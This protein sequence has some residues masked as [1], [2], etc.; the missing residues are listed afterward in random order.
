LYSVEHD[1]EAHWNSIGRGK[2]QA[3][4][5]IRKISNGTIKLWRFGAEYDLRGFQHT[6]AKDSTF[7][8]HGWKPRIESG[9]GDLGSR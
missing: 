1:I 8:L 5:R 9:L 7:F 6:L 4:A 3:C 2:L